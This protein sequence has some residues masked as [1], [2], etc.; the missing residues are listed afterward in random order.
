ME[1]FVV[2]LAS[3]RAEKSPEQRRQI[4]TK[5][6]PEATSRALPLVWEVEGKVAT[7]VETL[8]P[9]LDCREDEIVVGAIEFNLAD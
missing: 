5:L 8:D 7:W 3:E 1:R 2:V 9:N 6:A 4:R